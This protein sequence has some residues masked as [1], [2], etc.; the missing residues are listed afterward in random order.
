MQRPPKNHPSFQ[1]C[2]PL[3]RSN[4]IHA[5]RSHHCPSISMPQ[6]QVLHRC[7]AHQLRSRNSFVQFRNSRL[8]DCHPFLQ[9]NPLGCFGFRTQACRQ[10]LHPNTSPNR[11]QELRTCGPCPHL[12]LLQFFQAPSPL[13]LNSRLTTHSRHQLDP[14]SRCL[15]DP[16]SHP[17]NTSPNRC[18]ELRTCADRL[19]PEQLLSDPLQER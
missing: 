7:A 17:P 13:L 18:Q 3:E 9:R 11:C 16:V 2:G 15:V 4:Q 14:C 8:E 12:L 1:P 19:P 5:A 10:F 6:C